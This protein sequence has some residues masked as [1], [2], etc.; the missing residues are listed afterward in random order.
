MIEEVFEKL[1]ISDF[2]DQI[3]EI[4]IN[5]FTHNIRNIKS[6]GFDYFDEYEPSRSSGIV[7]SGFGECDTFPSV[8]TYEI[9][10]MLL[11]HLK[12]VREEEKSKSIVTSWLISK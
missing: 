11:N 5:L 4:A 10:G 2:I 12:Y 3:K 7:I 1:P 8:V 9:E 6:S